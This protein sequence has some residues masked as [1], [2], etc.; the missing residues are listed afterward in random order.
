ML[1]VVSIADSSSCCCAKYNFISVLRSLA[2][3]QYTIIFHPYQIC[4]NIVYYYYSRYHNAP[5]GE[6][7]RILG[8]CHEPSYSIEVSIGGG[9]KWC[10]GGLDALAGYIQTGNVQHCTR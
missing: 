10:S 3:T 4:I 6:L 5:S 2:H 8:E 7:N 1:V 9:F